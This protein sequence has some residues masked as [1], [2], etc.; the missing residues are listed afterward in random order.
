MRMREITATPAQLIVEQ[1]AASGVRYV[2][3][4]SGSREASFFDALHEHPDIHGILAL[5]EGSVTAMASG[6]TQVNFDPAVSLVHLGAGLAQ[7]LGQLINT[8][9]GSLPVV[10]LTFAG[11]TGS[12]ADRMGL[13]LSHDFGPTAISAPFTKAGWSVMEPDHLPHAVERALRAAKTPPVG[14]VHLAV[15]DRI[16]DM[17]PIRA[18]IADGPIPD[19]R[20]GHPGQDDVEAL[21]R[22]LHDSKRPMIYA[23]DGVSKSGARSALSAVAE[24]FG[25]PIAVAYPQS[26]PYSH[27]LNCGL[28]PAAVPAVDPDCVIAVGVRHPGR[29][30]PNDFAPF[31]GAE[32]ILAIGPDSR[33][34]RGLPGI[35]H[36][37]LADERRTLESVEL[38]P[39]DSARFAA[40]RAWARQTAAD[41]RAERR[42]RATTVPAQPGSV[43][44]ARLGDALDSTLR[45]AG[46]GLIAIEQFAVPV[47]VIGEYGGPDMNEYIFAAGGSEGYGVGATIGVKLAAPDKPVVGLVGDGSLYY[48]DSGLW[49]AAHHRVPGA[50]HNLEQRR[51]RHR[52]ELLRTRREDDER[53]GRVR[54]RRPRRHRPGEDRRR[55][56]RRGPPRRRRV[57]P[58]RRHRPR[59]PRQRRP[60]PAR[61]SSTSGSPSASP[62][63]AEPPPSSNSRQQRPP[64][65]QPSIL[66]PMP[67]YPHI[68]TSYAA[69][70]EPHISVEQAPSVI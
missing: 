38:D 48:A 32:R 61:S 27:P 60:R 33:N 5:H 58:R 50:L 57:A 16:L 10:V 42:R 18:Q 54:R 67:A 31:A 51:L 22:A 29:S 45:R 26:V 70:Q 44:P 21:T 39:N 56:R 15:Y 69:N 62:K 23:G 43:R 28:S 40:R 14:P 53:D 55:V 13:D 11:D 17:G 25:A 66:F 52:G 34:L 68:E 35:G 46:G 37:I 1:L 6:Y 2:F 4:N 20:A 49:T 12:Y 9:Q 63:A 3:N 65:G 36:A 8:W 47:D 59:P 41:L 19:L 30:S 64:K 7:S 24:H